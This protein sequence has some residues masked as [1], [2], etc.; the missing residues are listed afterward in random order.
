MEIDLAL[1]LVQLLLG[2]SFRRFHHSSIAYRYPEP[3]PDL[4]CEACDAPAPVIDGSTISWP[5][6]P[7]AIC[8]VVT[9]DGKVEGFTT[10]TSFAGAESGA[11]YQVQAV[12]EYGGLSAKAKATSA[13]DGITA[14]SNT[15]EAVTTGIY[16]ADGR[17]VSTMQRGLNIIM[18]S[19][20]TA[21]KVLRKP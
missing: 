19:D 14:A 2:K 8:Y 20:G 9:K 21:K 12:N 16:T 7:Y 11:V 17:R 13:G 3:Q 1:V 4:L 15:S 5:A 6:V 18:M 10:S